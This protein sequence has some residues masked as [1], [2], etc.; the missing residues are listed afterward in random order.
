MTLAYAE[1]GVGCPLS[2][3]HAAVPALRAAA[4]GLATE[5]EPLLGFDDATTRACDPRRQ[6]G[7]ALRDGDDRAAGGLGRPRQ[8]DPRRA[9]RRRTVSP[10]TSGSARRR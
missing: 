8:R 10:G 7:R 6:A 1:A 3:T 2:M 4:P 5:W 9:G